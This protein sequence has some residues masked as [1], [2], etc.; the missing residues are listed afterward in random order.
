VRE[1]PLLAE[2]LRLA[3]GPGETGRREE[4]VGGH[5][6]I[7]CGSLLC[8]A[9]RLRAVEPRFL[10]VRRDPLVL[11]CLYCGVGVRPRWGGSRAERRYHPLASAELRKVLPA[12][13]VW[14]ATRREAELAGFVRTRKGKGPPEEA[15]EGS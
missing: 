10:V 4:S 11:E 6:G 2:L 3:L 12:N 8:A 1:I 7:R 14:F 9:R 5:G 15:E 13:M